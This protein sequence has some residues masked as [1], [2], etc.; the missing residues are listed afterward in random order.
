MFA[1][2]CWEGPLIVSSF[3]RAVGTAFRELPIVISC[4][5]GL[6]RFDRS[7]TSFGIFGFGIVR[8]S[9]LGG[10]RPPHPPRIMR[11]LRPSNSQEKDRLVWYRN[12]CNRSSCE[13]QI[14]TKPAHIPTYTHA[15]VL[16]THTHI[17]TCTHARIHTCD[18]Y[19][20]I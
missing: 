6:G 16:Y 4:R 1:L 13:L 2:L 19:R 9:L 17:H 10:C 12:R 15:H 8:S 5:L 3:R 7:P 18:T 14:E 11:G 20:L